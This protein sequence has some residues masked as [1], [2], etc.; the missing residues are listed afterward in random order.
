MSNLLIR[1]VRPMGGAAAD[2]LIRDG[3]ILKIAAGIDAPDVSVIDGAGNLA[4]PGLVEAHTHLDKSLMG[5]G[6]YRNDVGS[7]LQAMIDNER[8]LRHDPKIDPH[9]QSMRHA[10]A[11]VGNG[12]THIRS[13]V[14][15]DTD[16]RLAMVE[17]VLATREALSG[18]VDIEI[19]AFPQSGLMVRPG[20]LELM[21]GALAQGADVIGGIDPAGMDRDPKGQLDALFDLAEQ[22]GKPI[23]IHLHEAGELGA[24]TTE[25]ILE[26]VRALAMEGRVVISHAFCLGMNDW[27][28]VGRLIEQIAELRVGI[29]TT[30]APSREVPSVLRLLEAGLVVG[31]GCD[32]VRDSWNPIQ[33]PDMRDRARIVAMKNN[34]RRDDDLEKVLD[35]C[36]GIGARMCG[37]ED[38][39]LQ[40]GARA[41]L[42][43]LDAETLAEVVVSDAPAALVVKGGQV[44]ARNG[45]SEQAAP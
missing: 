8:A 18:I 21:G 24:F 2:I 43:T 26:R 23:D 35:I 19:V 44:T 14:D 31:A 38:H 34:L 16:H 36:T 17:G 1:N 3:V 32:G 10:L 25:L 41:D 20:T 5:L 37:I 30:A 28:K 7:D 12:T 11:L 33:R 42:M 40:V 9:V 13:H 22:H 4:I 6:W 45:V 39:A 29:A 15:I 27:Q